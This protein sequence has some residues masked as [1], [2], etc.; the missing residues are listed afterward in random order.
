MVLYGYPHRWLYKPL[1]LWYY[2]NSY[3]LNLQ[4]VQENASARIIII[5]EK[6]KKKVRKKPEENQKKIRKNRN[7]TVG[8]YRYGA[9]Y[10]SGRG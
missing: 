1:K 7:I 9:Q 4:K 6:S 8:G 5:S 2:S 3:A 10:F